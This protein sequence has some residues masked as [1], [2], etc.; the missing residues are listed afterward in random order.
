MTT[1]SAKPVNRR[2]SPLF[3]VKQLVLYKSLSPVAEIRSIPFT[4][5]LNIIQGKSDDSAQDFEFGH[6]NGKTSLC[7]LIRYCLGE[8]TFGQQHI[9]EEVKYCFPKG[10]V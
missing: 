6:G 7:R 1:N 9:V 3:W 5:G 4:P 8:K 2:T 10:Y